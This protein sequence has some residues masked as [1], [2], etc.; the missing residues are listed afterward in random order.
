MLL[1]TNFS[2]AEPLRIGWFPYQVKLSLL[3]KNKNYATRQL[4]V[5]RMFK[6]MVAH[7]T[8]YSGQLMWWWTHSH[9]DTEAGPRGDS[10][11]GN[12]RAMKDISDF[13][14]KLYSR[15]ESMCNINNLNSCTI[16]FHVI[17]EKTE[18][19]SGDAHYKLGLLKPLSPMSPS[20]QMELACCLVLF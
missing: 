2:P 20:P 3:L 4:R 5:Q 15:F 13:T 7:F 6:L 9:P 19:D 17:I 1:D 8:A 16:I 18:V 12:F 11:V 14:L 10:F